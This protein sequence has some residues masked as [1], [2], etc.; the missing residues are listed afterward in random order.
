[1]NAKP[2]KL[3]EKKAQTEGGKDRQG[4]NKDKSLEESR[5]T[6]HRSGP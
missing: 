4:K 1:M 5:H 6:H 3:A 2:A